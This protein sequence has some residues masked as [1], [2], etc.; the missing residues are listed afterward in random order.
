ME[1]YN[2]VNDLDEGGPVSLPRSYVHV[3]RSSTSTTFC[4]LCNA[5]LHVYTTLLQCISGDKGR[6]QHQCSICGLQNESYTYM[7]TECTMFGITI[8]FLV[9]RAYCHCFEKLTANLTTAE[10]PMLY[11]LKN[12]LEQDPWSKRRVEILCLKWVDSFRRPPYFGA[13]CESALEAR[14][15]LAARTCTLDRS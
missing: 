2:L 10:S 14:T 3:S 8:S 13:C 11:R 7:D 5:S 4:G 1:Q 12:C 15:T 9:V 6:R